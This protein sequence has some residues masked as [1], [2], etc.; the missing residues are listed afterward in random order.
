MVLEKIAV[1]KEL[2]IFFRAAENC[3]CDGFQWN[4]RV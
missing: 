3:A 1:L 4:F 2:T